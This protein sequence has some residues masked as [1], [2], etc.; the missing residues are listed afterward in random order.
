M[1]KC[2]LGIIQENPCFACMLSRCR[3]FEVACPL[4]LMKHQ[5]QWAQT[6]HLNKNRLTVPQF[7]VDW[8]ELSLLTVTTFSPFENM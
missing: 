8:K 4:S 5:R 7:N 1:T 3:P 6:S 2:G